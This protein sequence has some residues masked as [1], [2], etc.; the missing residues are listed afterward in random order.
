MLLK[1]KDNKIVVVKTNFNM[2]HISRDKATSLIDS[3]DIHDKTL[4]ETI[5]PSSNDTVAKL[6]LLLKSCDEK[7]I[8][9]KIDQLKDY[10]EG[11]NSALSFKI[12]MEAVKISYPNIYR[13]FM[14][15][16]RYSQ[17]F[18]FIEAESIDLETIK[19]IKRY[20][21][22]VF[23]NEEEMYV[24]KKSKIVRQ[25]YQLGWLD[26]YNKDFNAF[27]NHDGEINSEIIDTI[28]YGY[29]KMNTLIK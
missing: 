19:Q 8:N 11:A 15:Y 6:E 23:Y 2:M 17:D 29:D 9:E 27:V 20:F 7:P 10:F 21:E 24:S 25:L 16:L 5:S 26:N 3:S 4:L 22:S 12:R 14:S 1:K 28:Q 13:L 18:S